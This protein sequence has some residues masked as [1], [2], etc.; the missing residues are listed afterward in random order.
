ML[1]IG[2]QFLRNFSARVEEALPRDTG[3]REGV[4]RAHC[5]SP[6]RPRETR[7][8]ECLDLQSSASDGE[9][10]WCKFDSW[11][12]EVHRRDGDVSLEGSPQSTRRLAK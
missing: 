10:D 12:S 7:Q 2:G 5:R 6:A 1:S 8:R 3:R 4:L 11:S 9:E